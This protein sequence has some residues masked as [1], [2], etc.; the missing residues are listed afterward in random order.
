MSPNALV[1]AGLMLAGLSQLPERIPFENPEVKKL[2]KA[3]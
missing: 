1:T 3:D 2:P